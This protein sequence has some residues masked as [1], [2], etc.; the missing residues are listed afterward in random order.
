MVASY[1]VCCMSIVNNDQIIVAEINIKQELNHDCNVI[2]RQVVSS[3]V[4]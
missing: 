1:Q 4:M 3:G 2:Y